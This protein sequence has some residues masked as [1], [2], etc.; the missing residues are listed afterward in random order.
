MSF[1]KLII[2]IFS[3]CNPSRKQGLGSLCSSSLH[4]YTEIEPKVLFYVRAHKSCQTYWQLI[5]TNILMKLCVSYHVESCISKALWQFNL[6][7]KCCFSFM[8]KLSEM[9]IWSA[10]KTQTDYLIGLMILAINYKIG[11][12][13]IIKQITITEWRN[14][15]YSKRCVKSVQ[16]WSFFWSVLSLFGMNIGKYGRKKTLYLDSFRVVK[17]ERFYYKGIMKLLRSVFRTLSKINDLQFLQ[18]LSKNF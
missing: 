8:L 14:F 13:Y 3:F 9:N 7:V 18:K 12:T 5:K 15:C 1:I 11:E 10:N 17:V 2:T 6:S 4:L 16:I